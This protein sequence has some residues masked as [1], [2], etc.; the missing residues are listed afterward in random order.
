MSKAKKHVKW[1][2]RKAQKELKETNDHKGLV[3]VA[4][5]EKEAQEHIKKAE[6]NLQALIFNKDRFS[7]WS[8][9]M[10]FYTMYHCCLAI[11]AKFGF[12]SKN[13][14]CTLSA[15]DFLVEEKKI[16]VSF[17]EY[18]EKIRKKP[19]DKKEYKTEKK[20]KQIMAEREETQYATILAVEKE[21]VNEIL[22]ICQEML[23]ETKGIVG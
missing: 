14:E 23:Q 8:I 6:H 7:D 17:R 1:C 10:G 4:P 21:K 5:D 11:L 22:K 20:D 2:L 16:D 3:R 9:N 13:Q 15:I 18:V 12:E 19:E